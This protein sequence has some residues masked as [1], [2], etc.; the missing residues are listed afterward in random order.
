MAHDEPQHEP[1]ARDAPAGLPPAR[2]GHPGWRVTLSAMWFAQLS[3]IMGF[4]FVMPFIPF[5]VRE[6]GVSGR[7][8]P[9]WAGLTASA[10]GITMSI[11]GPIWGYL[12]DRHGRKLMVV[13]AMLGGSVVLG[14]MGLARNVYELLALRVLQG[15][16]T[17]TVPASI[18]LVASVVPQQRL[19]F[20]LGLMQMAVFSGGSVGPYV[21]GMVA[22]RYGYRLPF[23]VTAALLFSGGLL[24]LFGARERFKP[25][26]P[27]ERRGG[28]P[29]RLLLRTPGILGLLSLFFLL[30]LSNSLVMPIF[31]L[32]VEEIVKSPQRAASQTG[33]LL[34]VTGIASAFAAIVAG[35]LS[36]RAGHKVTLV[37]CTVLTGLLCFPHYS[38]RTVAQLLVLRVLFGLAA[39]G[40]LPSMNALVANTVPR[41]SVG[42]AYG[43]TTTA[44]A[45]G[46][47]M[48]PALGGWAAS[49]FGY[50]LPFLI[51]GS[52]LLIVAAV[53]QRSVRAPR[54]EGAP[55]W[56]AEAGEGLET[57]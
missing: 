15:S 49:A 37:T 44:S 52:S 4:S 5:F 23:A 25:P 13:R 50:R 11:M 33:L 32:F 18:A 16:I 27:E 1:S 20:S 38:A 3:C 10:A 43:F 24:V 30:N 56:G 39:G 42:Q 12:A 6:L 51:M 40:M 31:P 41:S 28:A 35:R 17:G 9:V 14:L 55:A 7:M 21:G 2:D 29:L 19:G 53:A 26:P 34:A 46:W 36:D 47:A 8:V 22:D 48:G 54:G 57:D 45:I